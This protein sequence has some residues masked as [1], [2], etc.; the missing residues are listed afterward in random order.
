MELK[1]DDGIS[2][3][4]KAF[5]KKAEDILLQRWLLHYER[6]ISFLGFKKELIYNPLN[7]QDNRTTEE[8]MTD[9]KEILESFKKEGD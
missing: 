9:V 7:K 3:I 6:S 4:V 1:L 2:L 8:I 5:E